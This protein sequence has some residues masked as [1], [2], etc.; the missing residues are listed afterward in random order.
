MNIVHKL[1]ID[2]SEN[3][4]KDILAD[5]FRSKTGLK[6]IEADHVILEVCNQQRSIW[7]ISESHKHRIVGNIR[8]D[9]NGEV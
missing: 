5:Y 9:L 6:N 4:I 1:D 7:D 3:D 8:C 2:L